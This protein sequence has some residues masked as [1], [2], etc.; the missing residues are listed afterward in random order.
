MLIGGH[1]SDDK[2][3]ASNPLKIM[4]VAEQPTT[5]RWPKALLSAWPS[6]WDISIFSIL[7]KIIN[8]PKKGHKDTKKEFHCGLDVGKLNK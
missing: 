1:F 2:K 3:V 6:Q 4:W 5:M 8:R 7:P